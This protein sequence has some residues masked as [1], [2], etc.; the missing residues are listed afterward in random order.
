MQDRKL[1]CFF[2]E[3]RSGILAANSPSKTS[4]SPLVRFQA[5][6]LLLLEVQIQQR[7]ASTKQE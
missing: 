4:H 5:V 1:A 6:H 7:A 3:L 2:T